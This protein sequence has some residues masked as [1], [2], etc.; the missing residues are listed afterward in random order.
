MKS[1]IAILAF[2]L[3]STTGFA[4]HTASKEEWPALETIHGVI[5]QTF[6]PS[7]KGNLEPIQKRSGELVAKAQ[8]LAAST[9]PPSFNRPEIKEAAKELVAEAVKMDEAVKSKATDKALTEQISKVHDVFHKI[10]G[11]C[12]KDDE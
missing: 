1:I 12:S 8:Q 6:H 4:Q 3:L 9:P 7:E 11:L 2:F 10:V 5:G